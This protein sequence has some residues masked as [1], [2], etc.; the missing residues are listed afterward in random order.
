MNGSC[1]P[2]GLRERFS[3]PIVASLGQ[4]GN[5]HYRRSVRILPA[6]GVARKNGS[7]YG[8]RDECAT[9]TRAATFEARGVN[10]AQDY[11]DRRQY[12]HVQHGAELTR[13][14]FRLVELQSNTAVTQVNHV[15]RF[16]FHITEYGISLR[17]RERHPLPLALF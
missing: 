2:A 3:R 4:Y 1:P 11:A 10:L 7:F 5:L 14:L 12:G 9:N 8:L 6:Q 13:Q 17:S 16:L 15:R